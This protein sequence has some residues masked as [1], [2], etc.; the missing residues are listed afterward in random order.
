MANTYAYELGQ[1]FTSLNAATVANGGVA[2]DNVGVGPIYHGRA[3][4]AQITWEVLLSASPT[5][6]TV[7]LEG[8]LDGTNWYQLDQTTT[9]QATQARSVVYK[10]F[11]F[12]RINQTVA[13]GAA[14][15]ITGRIFIA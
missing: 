8:S 9:V 7:N 15:T 1:Y 13:T 2:G 5:T 10:P 11:R 14:G 4:P 3:T 6:I 12:Y